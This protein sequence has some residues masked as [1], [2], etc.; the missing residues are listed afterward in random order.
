MNLMTVGALDGRRGLA[1]SADYVRT[2]FDVHLNG[3]SHAS[4]MSL[5][6]RYSEIPTAG[7]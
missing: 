6:G 5:A 7:K 4:L 1:L 2:F 3:A